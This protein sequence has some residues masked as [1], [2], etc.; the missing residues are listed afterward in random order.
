LPTGRFRF[1]L[2]SSFE[3]ELALEL[4]PALELTE[5]NLSSEDINLPQFYSLILGKSIIKI[6]SSYNYKFS[7]NL[8]LMF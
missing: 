4:E 3:L 6:L 2:D 1:K 8:N 7:K 5:V